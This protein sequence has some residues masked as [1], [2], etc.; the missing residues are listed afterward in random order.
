M[1]RAYKVVP[2]PKDSKLKFQLMFLGNFK[3]AEDFKK[4]MLGKLSDGNFCFVHAGDKYFITVKDG[5]IT[6]EET[7]LGEPK[8]TGQ[9]SGSVDIEDRDLRSE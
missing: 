1:G 4:A 5:Q 8:P 9:E 7:R 6:D 2:P 3:R